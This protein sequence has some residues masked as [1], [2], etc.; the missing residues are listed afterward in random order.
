LARNEIVIADRLFKQTTWGSRDG[1]DAD[2]RVRMIRLP[3]YGSEINGRKS[4][5]FEMA[6]DHS[7]LMEDQLPAYDYHPKHDSHQASPCLSAITIPCRS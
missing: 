2:N 4:E 3:A 7:L 1:A 6:H 5:T